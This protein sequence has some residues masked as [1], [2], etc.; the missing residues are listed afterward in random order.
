MV[1]A[2][3]PAKVTAPLICSSVIDPVELISIS[4]LLVMVPDRMPPSLLAT[5]TVPLL[6]RS[7]RVP[8][9]VLLPLKSMTP[10]SDVC[11]V[12]P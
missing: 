4:P 9:A 12:P 7:A 5:R 1:T 6:V 10:L 2:P 11:N 8:A 3:S